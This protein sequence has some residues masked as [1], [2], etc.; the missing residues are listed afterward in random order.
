[1]SS[2]RY[3]FARLNKL[4]LGVCARVELCC[5]CVCGC[6]HVWCAH[7]VPGE[8]AGVCASCCVLRFVCARVFVA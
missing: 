3:L 6:V 2:A 4:V 5:V 7:A 1:M 8:R